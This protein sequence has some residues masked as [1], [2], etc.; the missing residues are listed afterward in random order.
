MQQLVKVSAGQT[1]LDPFCGSGS[2]GVACA[3]MGKKFIGIELD[4]RYF[5]IACRRIHDAYAQPDM[6]A[7]YRQPLVD[8]QQ[9]LFASEVAP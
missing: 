9:P 3:M 5:D 4:E 1:I 2:T 6:F 7:E 8:Q